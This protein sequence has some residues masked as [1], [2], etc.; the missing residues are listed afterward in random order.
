VRL[1]EYFFAFS[2]K[3]SAREGGK[4]NAL[5]TGDG[6]YERFAMMMC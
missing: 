2:V 1:H 5:I 4:N 6:D 3:R